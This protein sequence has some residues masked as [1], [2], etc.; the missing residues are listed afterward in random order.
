MIIVAEVCE[1]CGRIFNRDTRMTLIFDTGAWWVVCRWC[2]DGFYA[3][4]ADDAE[5]IS[6]LLRSLSEAKRA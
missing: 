6:E 2:A 5:Y 3:K 4:K 1:H